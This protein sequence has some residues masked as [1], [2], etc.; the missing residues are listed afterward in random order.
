MK[1]VVLADNNPHPELNLLTEH[2]LSIYFE[3]DGLKWLFDVG[4]STNFFVNAKHIGINIS[5]IDY[6]VLSHGHSD[7]TGG[8]GKFLEVNSKAQILMSA[9]IRG[10]AY[11]S[12]R[13]EEKR[14]IGIDH[15]FIEQN[16]DRF[17][18]AD[19]NMMISKNVALI[20]KFPRKYDTPRANI[21]LTRENA[22]GE[23]PDEFKHEAAL[24]V[25][26]PSGVVVFSGCSHNGILNI[27][28]ACTNYLHRSRIIACVGGTHLRDS[29]SLNTY[30][31]LSEIKNTG[32]AILTY[33]PGMQLITGHCTG[34]K[35][36]KL[37]YQVMGDKFS[38]FHTGAAFNILTNFKF[39]N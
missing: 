5:D 9:H 12:Y 20:L 35:V 13:L 2:G 24:C 8:L 10:E 34:D 1:V 31:S 19:N 26:F 30:E 38:V 18:F 36:K 17:V 22:D 27:L 7:H 33:H 14:N 21:R 6:L 37:L 25:N 3:A 32:R 15:S 28:E 11:Y 29:D 23:S 16:S 4:A 39:D